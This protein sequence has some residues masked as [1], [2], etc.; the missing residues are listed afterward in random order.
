MTQKIGLSSVVLLSLTGIGLA[1][2]ATSVGTSD[3]QTATSEP[4]QKIEDKEVTGDLSGLNKQSITIDYNRSG[5]TS[6]EMLLSLDPQIQ[7]EG[8]QSLA[9]LKVGD[10]VKVKYQQIYKDGEKNERIVLKNMATSI[11]IVRTAPT[12]GGSLVSGQDIK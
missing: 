11:A 5:G 2:E 8:L 12:A 4:P 6:Y 7:L 1:A 3:I 9:E 10:T